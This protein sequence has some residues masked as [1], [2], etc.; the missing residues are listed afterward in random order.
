MDLLL[1][2][3]L[4][5]C[6]HIRSKKTGNGKMRSP[7]KKIRPFEICAAAIIFAAAGAFGHRAVH[8]ETVKKIF[9]END[10][11]DM[12]PVKGRQPLKMPNF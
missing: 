9:A 3:C 8:A 7:E 12:P 4:L 1:T 10:K 6:E 11:P 2:L 5:L